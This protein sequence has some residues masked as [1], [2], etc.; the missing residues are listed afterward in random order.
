M[1][2]ERE[3]KIRNFRPSDAEACLRIRAEAFSHAFTDELDKDGIAAGLRA[4][5]PADLIRISEQGKSFVAD[6][7]GPA[8]F[9][10]IRKKDAKTAELLFVYVKFDRL[11]QGLGA[12]LV[13]HGEKW[14]LANWPD[15]AWFDVETVVP[16]YNRGFY[17]RLGFV[18]QENTQVSF[19]GKI[20]D[21]L[22]LRKQIT[23]PLNTTSDTP[24]TASSEAVQE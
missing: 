3:M 1:L 23:K 7:D 12:A 17:E 16:R 22:N 2:S 10:T 18:Q 9:C 24:P 4:Y 14:I 5:E 20:V 15:I 8:G 19:P 21:A 13:N 6:D 11:K